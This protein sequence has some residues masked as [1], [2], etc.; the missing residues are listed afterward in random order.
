MVPKQAPRF[1]NLR[2]IT[3]SGNRAFLPLSNRRP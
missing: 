3:L 2:D 1:S